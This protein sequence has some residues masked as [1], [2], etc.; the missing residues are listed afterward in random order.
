MSLLDDEL[1]EQPE[2]LARLLDAELPRL[3]DLARALG[4]DDVRYVVIAA[5]G[6]SDNAARYAQ[7]L[8]GI[9]NG[10]PV[11][12]ATPS[13]LTVY[14]AE[15]RLDGAL[16]IGVSQSG[17]SPDIVSVVESARRQG[18]P[19]VAVTNDGASPLAEQATATLPLHAG[20]ERS[21]AATKTYTTSLTA[22]ALCSVALTPRAGRTGAVEELRALPGTVQQVLDGALERSGAVETLAGLEHCA[23]VGRGYNYSTAFEVALKIKE[24]TGVLAEPYSPADLLHGPIA[25]VGAGAPVLLLAP[26]EPSLASVRGI[27]GALRDRGAR[28][29]AFSDDEELLAAADLALPFAAQP[30]PWLTPVAAVVPGQVLAARLVTARGG[31]PD[32]PPGLQKVTRTS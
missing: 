19:S 30:A 14:D 9:R 28:L 25:A 12:L 22:L 24:L 11:A 6:S 2:A 16:V 7:Y 23:V 3:D 17:Q 26:R 18:R 21:V 4:R 5:R 15:P 27:V 10:L 8:F 29:V 20:P 31:D 32:N 13:V 1:R